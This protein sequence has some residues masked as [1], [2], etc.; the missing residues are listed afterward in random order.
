MNDCEDTCDKIW[1]N[2][3]PA[4]MPDKNKEDWIKIAAHFYDRT[5]FPNVIGAIDGKC[6]R[7]VPDKS[8]SKNFNYTK[9]FS[10]VLM[11]WINADYKFVFI[12]IG[13]FG[14][15][16]DSIIFK[17]SKMGQMLE[18][19]WLKTLYQVM[20]LVVMSF[21]VVADEAFG[22]SKQVLHPYAK[23]NLTVLKRI[24]NYWHTRARRLVECIFGI[25]ANKWRILQR[26]LEVNNEFCDSI[27]MY[28]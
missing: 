28:T 14:A 5:N 24:V 16:S 22:L 3:Q 20:K 7:I 12:Y 10:Q 27:I 9:Y 23:N 11:A 25:L 18:Q 13:S 17:D 21:Y 8:G 6:M 15:M 4:Y 2:L 1:D 19:N 26:P